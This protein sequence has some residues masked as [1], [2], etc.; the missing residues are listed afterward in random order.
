MERRRL[1]S[2]AAASTLIPAL[3]LA[4]EDKKKSGGGSYLPLQTLLGTT[5]RSSGRRGVLAVDCGL[6]VPDPA[7][8]LRAEQSAPRLRAAYVQSVQAYAAGL[9]PG[10]LPNADYLA[11]QLQRHTDAILGRPGARVLLGAIVVN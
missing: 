9:A 6:D 7:L 11:Q 2:L 1:L 10:A 4:A 5:I 8:R 3:A